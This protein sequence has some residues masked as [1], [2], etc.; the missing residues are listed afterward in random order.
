M[1]VVLSAL[2]LGYL[3]RIRIA[4]AN[5][6]ALALLLLKA[7]PPNLNAQQR[8]KLNAL[9][10]AGRGVEA[11]QSVREDGG[12]AAVQPLRSQLANSIAALDLSLEALSLLPPTLTDKS[13][14]AQKARAVVFP[15]GRSFV[16]ASAVEATMY[17]RRT[18]ARIDQKK[19]GSEL[20]DLVGPEFLK[21]VQSA[22]DDLAE[23]LG[24]GDGVKEM[25]SATAISDA[26]AKYTTALVGYTRALASDL[27]EDDE[28]SCQRFLAAVAPIDQFRSTHGTDAP[29]ATPETPSAPVETAAPVTNGAAAH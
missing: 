2:F 24:L 25:P 28:A 5:A 15:D 20:K 9:Q 3:G 6:M 29:A 18:L 26:M 17:V 14:R 21:N 23:A 1:A 19:L 12:G 13:K 16:N 8:K 22:C 27:D 10:K 7:A 11:V 4:A